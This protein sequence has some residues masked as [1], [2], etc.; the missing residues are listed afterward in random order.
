MVICLD[1]LGSYLM[2]IKAM[3]C[4]AENLGTCNAKFLLWSDEHKCLKIPNEK[5]SLYC[6]SR[7]NYYQDT[8]ISKQ[9]KENN[10]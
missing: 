9:K 8:S 5:G 1:Q 3:N 4:S 6:D 7:F 10:N 2:C